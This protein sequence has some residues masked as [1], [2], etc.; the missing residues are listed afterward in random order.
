MKYI[1][2]GRGTNVTDG[3]RSAIEDKLGKHEHYFTPDTEGHV[4][5]KGEKERQ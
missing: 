3:L 5:L 2:T 4:S 1:I